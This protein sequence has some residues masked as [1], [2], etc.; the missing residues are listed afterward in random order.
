MDKEE[1]GHW[2]GHL[3]DLFRKK[4]ACCDES[5]R[6]NDEIIETLDNLHKKVTSEQTT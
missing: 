2:I 5:T 6:L 1:F 3:A 4:K